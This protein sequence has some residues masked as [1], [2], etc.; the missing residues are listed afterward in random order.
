M[1]RSD[2]RD[3]DAGVPVKN[4]FVHYD[5]L[6]QEQPE[7][8]KSISN[9]LDK[10]DESSMGYVQKFLDT[11]DEKCQMGEQ[12]SLP[13][14]DSTVALDACANLPVKN[15]F[16]HYDQMEEQPTIGK[17]ISNMVDKRDQASKTYID[18]FSQLVGNLKEVSEVDAELP[19]IGSAGHGNG[20]CKPCAWAWKSKGCSNGKQCTFCHI[21]DA[22]EIKRRRRNKTMQL[23]EEERTEK[24]TTSSEP[25]TSGSQQMAGSLQEN[26]GQPYATSQEQTCSEPYILSN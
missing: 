24:E 12:E 3:G 23:R 6:N 21:C 26:A 9:M 20:T 10:R 25:S 19:S 16:V 1:G 2:V 4:T 7:I 18:D 5:D 22:G 14:S 8:S 11:L 15:T 17:S 13:P